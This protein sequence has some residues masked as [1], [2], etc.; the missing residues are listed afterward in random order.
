M[1]AAEDYPLALG[2]RYHNVGIL[3]AEYSML[4]SGAEPTLRMRRMEGWVA[5]NIRELWNYGDLL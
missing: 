2:K 4:M 3:N 5:L 1:R